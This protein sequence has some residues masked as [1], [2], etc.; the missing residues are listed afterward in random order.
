MNASRE[1][2]F[3]DRLHSTSGGSS[4]TELNELTVSPSG[5]PSGPVAVTTVTPVAKRP[6]AV[7]K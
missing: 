3:A 2:E 6:S 7:R 5:L 4:E 1:R